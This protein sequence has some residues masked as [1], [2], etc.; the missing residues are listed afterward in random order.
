MKHMYYFKDE[1]AKSQRDYFPHVAKRVIEI[2]I[3]AQA[4]I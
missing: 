2:Q 1:Q 4:D 3:R